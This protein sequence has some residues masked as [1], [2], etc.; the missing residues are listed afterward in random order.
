MQDRYRPSLMIARS[1]GMRAGCGERATGQDLYG[2]ELSP[3]MAAATWQGTHEELARLERAVAHNCDCASGMLGLPPLTCAAHLMLG[4]Q[5]TLDHL[6]YVYR[7][8]RVFMAREFYAFPVQATSTSRR[9][10]ST[11]GG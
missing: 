2:K 4:D 9:I 7:T 1:A 11:P 6:L 8:R 10:R 3:R 5:T